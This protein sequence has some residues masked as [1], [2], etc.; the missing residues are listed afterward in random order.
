MQNLFRLL[1][2]TALILAFGS[3]SFLTSAQQASGDQVTTSD[4]RILFGEIQRDYDKESY[5]SIR[6]VLNDGKKMELGPNEVLEFRL[7][8]G[9]Y[10]QSKILSEKEEKVFA[11]V[12]IS[13]EINLYRYQGTLYVERGHGGLY[14]M[15]VLER[16]VEDDGRE[17]T[18]HYREYLGILNLLM[19][20]NECSLIREP[21]RNN[22]GTNINESELVRII[23]NFHL[24][25]NLPYEIHVIKIPLGILSPVVKLGVS[26]QVVSYWSTESQ[27]EAY[28]ENPLNFGLSAFLKFHQLRGIP[29][30]SFEIGVG[31][32]DKSNTIKVKKDKINTLEYGEEVYNVQSLFIPMEVSYSIFRKNGFDVSMGFG[33]SL[34]Y[35]KFKSN[36]SYQDYKI[37]IQEVIY[38]S[39][40]PFTQFNTNHFSPSVKLGIGKTLSNNSGLLVE[41]RGDFFKDN[42]QIQLEQSNSVHSGKMFS[43]LLGYQFK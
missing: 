19:A 35:E 43:I 37:K 33:G 28:L 27:T 18:R 15:R 42:Y 11:Q 8:N 26:H 36:D 22:S 13:G 32:W 40:Q 34:W 38:A 23:E 30:V 17:K 10:F 1:S 20:N 41:L 2:T 21:G 12:I 4:G 3:I 14:K 24:C 7:E 29:R 16:K 5:N 9:R 39:T 25:E 6:I 31:F